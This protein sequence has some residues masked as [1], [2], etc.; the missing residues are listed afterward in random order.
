MRNAY[1]GRPKF[2]ESHKYLSNTLSI[3]TDIARVTYY[4]VSES[5]SEEI[6][7]AECFCVM[8]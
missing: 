8:E 6:I 5:R 7:A 3:G 1:I 2:M 4:T